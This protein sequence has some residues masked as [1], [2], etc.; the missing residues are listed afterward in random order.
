[1]Q[2][3]ISKALLRSANTLTIQ[4][5]SKRAY[6]VLGMKSYGRIDIRV[7][8]QGDVFI[9]EANANPSLDIDDEFVLS[10]ER[11]GLTYK[12]LVRKLIKL[13]FTPALLQSAVKRCCQ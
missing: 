1:M 13:A 8:P 5:V 2:M 12:K 7:T 11:A 9:I 4:E 3:P 10:A 6:R